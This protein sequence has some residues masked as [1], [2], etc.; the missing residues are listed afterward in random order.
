[1]TG[2]LTRGRSHL[3]QASGH[4]GGFVPVGS[5]ANAVILTS[6]AAGPV[7]DANFNKT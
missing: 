3:N 4:N 6:Y 5:P 7:N 2:E 1:M